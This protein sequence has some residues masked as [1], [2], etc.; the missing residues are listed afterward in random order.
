MNVLTKIRLIF[1]RRSF[2]SDCRLCE[3]FETCSV[4]CGKGV[5]S[6]FSL[7]SELAYEHYWKY[8]CPI[9]EED[10][11]AYG[12]LRRFA[13]ELSRSLEKHPRKIRGK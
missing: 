2:P 11:L 3:K 13:E 10:R 9:E 1:E 4:R 8:L 7:P 6:Y 12:S 5:K